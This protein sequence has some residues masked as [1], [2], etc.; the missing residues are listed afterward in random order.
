MTTSMLPSD[1]L[2]PLGEIEKVAGAAG[3]RFAFR[4]SSG[5]LWRQAIGGI[6]YLPVAYSGSMIDYQ[7][8]YANGNGLEVFDA[9]MVLLHNERPCAIWPLS[10]SPS[11]EVPIGSNGAD[12]LPPMF[13]YDLPQQSRKTI[14]KGCLE[15]LEEFTLC[16]GGRSYTSVESARDSIAISS[17]HVE[18]LQR[19]SEPVIQYDLFV[20]L[21]LSIEE[22]RSALRKSYKSLVTSGKRHWKVSVLDKRDDAVWNEFR[23][24]HKTVSGRVTR[25]STTWDLQHLAIEKGDAIL[26]YL[27]ADDGRMVGGGLFHMTSNEGLY[28]V[29]AY[30]RSLF[31]K[32]L[33]HVIQFRAIEELKARGV[34]WYC[35]GPAAY[36]GTKP[37]PTPK[38]VSIGNFKR[39][40]ATHVFPRY[41]LVRNM[42]VPGGE[43]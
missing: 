25:A 32:P 8:A 13:C 18:S 12:V 37:T 4:T 38:E 21:T 19:G 5:H 1:V 9:S 22:I 35:L 27:N 30:D 20:D 7:V 40:F 15:F 26:V 14:V 43:R 24:L 36:P 39:G 10:L 28:A 33:G 29:G 41:R 42:D 23:I 34:R 6:T 2:N 16:N 31:D 3:L 11:A 17:W